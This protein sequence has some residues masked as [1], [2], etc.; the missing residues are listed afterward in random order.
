[1]ELLAGLDDGDAAALLARA[2]ALRAERANSGRAC[3]ECSTQSCASCAPAELQGSA[4][5]A[6]VAAC[7]PCIADDV[8]EPR[9]D[10]E[11][12]TVAAKRLM[13]AIEAGDW[14]TASELLLFADLEHVGESGWTCIHWAVHAACSASSVSDSTPITEGE[15]EVP[16]AGCS[17]CEPAPSGPRS[18]PFLRRLLAGLRGSTGSRR[19]SLVD[20]RGNDGATAL[21]F[22]AD[23][24]D[25][26]VCSWLLE[27]GADA[28]LEDADGDA[29]AVWARQRGHSELAQHLQQRAS[30]W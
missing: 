19:R 7:E 17:C 25:E 23:A 20:L 14:Q 24:G 1:M 13:Q 30:A 26:E 6:V 18:R 29:A 16:P 9:G 5:S 21:M 22:A 12:C 2:R 15:H 4:D 27:A 11:V 28:A 8:A 3:R 10:A